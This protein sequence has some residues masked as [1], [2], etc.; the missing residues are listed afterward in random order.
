[1]ATATKVTVADVIEQVELRLAD[2]DDGAYS[3]ETLIKALRDG[4]MDL[5][6][7]EANIQTEDVTLS[8]TNVIYLS[9]SETNS[10]NL[11]YDARRVFAVE[12]GGTRLYNAPMHEM[13]APS[14]TGT[15]VWWT[16][17][18]SE[19]WLSTSYSGLLTI[20]YSAYPNA[21]SIIATGEALPQWANGLQSALAAYME[22]RARLSEQDFLGA[23]R[24]A[25]EYNALKQN[26]TT[27]AR[28][29]FI[30]GGYTL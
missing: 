16:V 24:A 14:G 11:N 2:I 23:D 1:M 7:S 27:V 12:I 3:D 26:L 30:T 10:G 9:N 17:R 13:L 18:G 20:T 28:D 15:P 8:G 29:N 21:I 4:L 19:L 22:Y 6:E 5:A 25:A